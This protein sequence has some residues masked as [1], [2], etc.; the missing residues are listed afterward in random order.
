MVKQLNATMGFYLDYPGV[1]R[2]IM[3]AYS[4]GYK[5]GKKRVKPNDY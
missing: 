1:E 3:I 2:A 4:R 5:N